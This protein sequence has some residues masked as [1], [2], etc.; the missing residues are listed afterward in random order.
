M[1]AKALNTLGLILNI[2]GVIILFFFSF[3]Q[4]THEESVGIGLEDATLLPN[5]RTVA[6][7]AKDVQK[8]T[9]ITS[10]GQKPP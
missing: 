6:E 10:F 5:G 1:V 4:P 9:R 3:P 7:H 8:L 2:S